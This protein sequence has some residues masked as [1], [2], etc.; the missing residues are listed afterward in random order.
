MK[1]LSS[2]VDHW[3]SLCGVLQNSHKIYTN[4]CCTSNT[5]FTSLYHQCQFFRWHQWY[6]G[7]KGYGTIG[8]LH[9]KVTWHHRSGQGD[10]DQDAQDVVGDKEDQGCGHPGHWDNKLTLEAQTLHILLGGRGP[11]GHLSIFFFKFM[12]MF[13]KI[14]GFAFGFL[15]IVDIE[16]IPEKCGSTF[17]LALMIK[18]GLCKNLLT[19]VCFL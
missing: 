14:K 10:Q 19:W 1:E 8:E 12:I 13:V 11:G 17:Q 9:C 18:T 6:N 5:T 3:R 7:E 15:P 2:Y 4:A 16:L